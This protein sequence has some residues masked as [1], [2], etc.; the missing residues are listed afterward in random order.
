M[1][2]T[3]KVIL[4]IA[5]LILL[6]LIWANIGELSE[7]VTQFRDR[8]GLKIALTAAWAYFSWLAVCLHRATDMP[9]GFDD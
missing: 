7:E 8:L 6:S 5:W 1:K 2:T 4:I 9:E 3:V